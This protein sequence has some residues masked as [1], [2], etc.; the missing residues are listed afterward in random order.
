MMVKMTDMMISD[1]EP[2]SCQIKN[3]AQ[4]E[5][6]SADNDEVRKIAVVSN[7][8]PITDRPIFQSSAR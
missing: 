4:K 5:A 1:C 6:T 2:F 3:G 8:M 7:Q